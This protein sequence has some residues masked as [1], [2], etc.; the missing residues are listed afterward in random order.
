MYFQTSGKYSHFFQLLTK[1]LII[2]LLFHR[3]AILL[4]HGRATSHPLPHSFSSSTTDL[5]LLLH[6]GLASAA[7]PR[8]CFY[9]FT[10]VIGFF[11]LFSVR[12]LSLTHLYAPPPLFPP[13]NA[14]PPSSPSILLFFSL[15]F[16]CFHCRFLQLAL[17]L[18]FRYYQLYF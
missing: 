7:P 10:T 11:F 3:R 13:A 12:I 15:S 8:T 1:K 2:V 16:L 6:H 17:I 14:T 5:L 18:R 4:F 9:C